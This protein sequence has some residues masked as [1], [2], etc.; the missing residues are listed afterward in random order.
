MLAV[1]RRFRGP[2]LF[3]GLRPSSRLG[4]PF[5][6]SGLTLRS[7][8][9]AFCGPLTLAVRFRKIRQ[10]SSQNFMKKFTLA[11]L[12]SLMFFY[13]SS[14][15]S[16]DKNGNFESKQE[17][18]VYLIATLKN[19][20][21]EINAQTPIQLDE[22]TKLT[23]VIALQKTITFNYLLYRTNYK[24]VNPQE[25]N[26]IALENLNHSA[27]QSKATKNLIDA[28]VEYVYIYFSNDGKQITR[29]SIKNYR[30]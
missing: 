10:Q 22:Y 6:P 14:A 29:A 26:K 16:L 28:G 18:D 4:A 2:A 21:K 20:A 15:L 24:D 13:S 3:P 8:G 12:M 1:L 25:L 23:S 9:P 7:S 17:Q 5:W 27:C 11:S 30:C 19:M